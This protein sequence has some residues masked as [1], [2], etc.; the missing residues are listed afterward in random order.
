M[1][2]FQKTKNILRGGEYGRRVERQIRKTP[3]GQG[4]LDEFDRVT[5]KHPLTS[6]I[7]ILGR[8]LSSKLKRYMTSDGAMMKRK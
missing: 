7:R 3:E 6:V 1:A 2:F 8:D 4:R 5:Q